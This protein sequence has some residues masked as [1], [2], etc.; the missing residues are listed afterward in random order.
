MIDA[1]L[2]RKEE[3]IAE[4]RR[5]CEL[6]PPNK[7]ALGNVVLAGNLAQILAWTGE[8]AAAVEQIAAM[9]RGPNLL[10]YGLLKLHPRWD[11]LR[12]DKR[13]EAVVASLAPTPVS[14]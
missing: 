2:G 7:D 3:A 11:D 12:N 6:L 1:G 5:A 13:F 8:K 10:S 4:G 14:K 9:Q